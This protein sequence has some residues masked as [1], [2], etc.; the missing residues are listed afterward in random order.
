MDSGDVSTRGVK[1]DHF[2]LGDGRRVLP[3]GD[4]QQNLTLAFGEAELLDGFRAAL[5][6]GLVLEALGRQLLLETPHEFDPAIV[7]NPEC[8][9]NEQQKRENG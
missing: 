2:G 1:G 3:L 8:A 4:E 6:G 7:P 9:G 5:G